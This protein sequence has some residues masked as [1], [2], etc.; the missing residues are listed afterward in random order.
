VAAE[1]SPHPPLSVA[2]FHGLGNVVQLLPI[3]RS[4]AE[5]GRDVELITRPE[6]GSV[7]RYLV[8]EISFGSEP[9]A[10]TIDLDAVTRFA[11]PTESRTD[12][13][14]EALG[15][16]G[17]EHRPVVLPPSWLDEWSEVKGAVLFAPEAAHESR[18]CPDALAL[19]IAGHFR[20]DRL[21]VVGNAPQPLVSCHADLRGKTGLRDLLILVRQSA[22]V[23]SMD[24]AMLHIATLL[25]TPAVALFSGIDPLMRTHEWQRV[26]VLVGDVPCRPCN[27]NETCNGEYF[28]LKRIGGAD[29]ARAVREVRDAR[30]RTLRVI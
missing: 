2:R 12:E 21:V 5:Q 28:C 16:S 17:V 27:K 15:I 24:S 7:F 4:H 19:D 10:A 14:A 11:R 6:W 30:G 20:D 1:I 22:V 26:I 18:R 3:L 25:G 29:V 8:P 23:I 13:F 9:S